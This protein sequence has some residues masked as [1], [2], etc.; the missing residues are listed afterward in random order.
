MHN[1]QGVLSIYNFVRCCRSTFCS[2]FMKNFLF[3]LS[4]LRAKPHISQ[5]KNV[6]TY[7]LS[8]Y[9]HRFHF[10]R[11]FFF[12][13]SPVSFS[14]LFYLFLLLVVFMLIS[15]DLQC[16]SFAIT[17]VQIFKLSV[18]CICVCVY[19]R[20][21]ESVVKN[22][23]FSC[24]VFHKM[25]SKSKSLLVLLRDSVLFFLFFLTCRIFTTLDVVL[26]K[27]VVVWW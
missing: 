2:C 17:T 9:L 5:V 22:I 19:V 6:F 11:F 26:F 24:S 3:F 10:F 23:F 20:E 12:W 21:R 7:G 25:L 16:A 15:M 27:D 18:H 13:F 8:A 4:P 14:E 1:E